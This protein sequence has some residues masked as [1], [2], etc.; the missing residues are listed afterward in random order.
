MKCCLQQAGALATTFR[1]ARQ[2]GFH[3]RAADA[4]IL[5]LGIDGDRPD[6]CNR[7]AFVEAVAA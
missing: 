1:G 2:H 6:A 4:L 7:R 5:D 3:E